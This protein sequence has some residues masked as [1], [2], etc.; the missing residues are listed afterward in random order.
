MQLPKHAASHTRSH[1]RREGKEMIRARS[2]KETRESSINITR[3]K[4]FVLADEI[5]TLGS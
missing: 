2:C 5:T 1:R 4:I 3:K